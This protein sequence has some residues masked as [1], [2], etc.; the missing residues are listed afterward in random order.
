MALVGYS[1]TLFKQ[2]SITKPDASLQVEVSGRNENDL[3]YIS[4]AGRL[5]LYLVGNTEDRLSHDE[6]Y[7]LV[8][9]CISKDLPCVIC[10]VC[11]KGGGAM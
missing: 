5:E 9:G 2:G 1:Y 6:A 4:R 11:C 8:H 3:T 7:I 10:V